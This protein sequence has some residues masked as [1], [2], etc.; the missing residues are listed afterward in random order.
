MRIGMVVPGNGFV[1]GIERHAH[2][3]ARSLRERG[4]E[5]SLLFGAET[6]KEPVRYAA[7]FDRALPARDARRIRRELDVVW[8]H[9]ANDARE[10]D[11]FADLP[12]V[13]ASHDHELTCVRS[14]RYL[15]LGLEPC[16]RAPGAACVTHGCVVVRDRRPRALLP[17]ALRSPFRLRAAL[18]ALSRRAPLVA[19]SRYV[20]GNLVRAGVPPSRVHV[21]HPIPR[22]DGARPL[23]R[24]AAPRLAVV[25]NLLRGKGVDIAI[26]ALAHL[27]REVTLDV[28]GDGPSRA[29][30]ESLAAKMAPGR[31]RFLGWLDPVGVDAAYAEVSLVVVPSR[32][33]EPFGMTGIEAMRRGRPVVGA[34]HGG[35]PEWLEPGSAGLLFAPGSAREL[36]RAAMLLLA[37][38]HAGERAFHWVQE[39]FPHRRLIDGVLAIASSAIEE[40]AQGS[41]PARAGHPG[42]VRAEGAGGPRNTDEEA[43]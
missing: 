3:V 21:L 2:D 5:V 4:H 13:V 19:C 1:G 42:G 41:P 7:A 28:V 39:R 38:E 15:P 16:H 11:A 32:W 34:D 22:E 8:I 20:A 33:P 25:G 9:R 10:L 40:G 37:D 6:G 36:A 31:V 23:P 26:E 43:A 14:H 29:S 17:V 12:V 18:R 35:I 24:P 30:L 27:P